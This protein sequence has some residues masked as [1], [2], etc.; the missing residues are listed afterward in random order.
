[1]IGSAALLESYASSAALR[2]MVLTVSS[3]KRLWRHRKVCTQNYG[4][5]ASSLGSTLWGVAARASRHLAD[6][7]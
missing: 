4:K 1:M 6:R 2:M 5:V 7:P 3:R